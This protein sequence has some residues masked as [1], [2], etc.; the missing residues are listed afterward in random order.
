[1]SFLANVSANYMIGMLLGSIS[2]EPRRLTCFL[3]STLIDA[4]FL[5]VE[6]NRGSSD[7]SLKDFS[8]VKIIFHVR[9]L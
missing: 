5:F 4:N 2:S 3:L 1:M 6:A 8:M 9:Q 7:I